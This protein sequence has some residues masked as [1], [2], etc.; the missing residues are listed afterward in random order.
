MARWIMLKWRSQGSVPNTEVAFLALGSN[1]GD[2]EANLAAALSLASASPGCELLAQ[3][4]IDETTA[5][6]PGEQGPY[7]NQMIAVRTDMSP[8]ELLSLCMEIEKQG[9]RVRSEDL[10]RWCPRTIDVDIVTFGK[11]V[12]NEPDLVIPHP[13]LAHRNFWQREL[14][15]LE[16]ILSDRR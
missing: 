11:K 4:S 13:Q 9:G 6:G 16:N 5:V 15:E 8:E 3:S 14:K 10:P 1:L 2:R 7:L 12:V